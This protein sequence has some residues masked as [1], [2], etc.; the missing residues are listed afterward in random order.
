MFLMQNMIKFM[1]GILFLVLAAISS[2]ASA[3]VTINGYTFSDDST[4]LHMNPYF[5]TYSRR[6]DFQTSLYGY[7][8]FGGYSLSQV[9]H[10]TF[11]IEG[12]ECIVIRE[13]ISIPK[14]GRLSSNVDVHNIYLYYAKD[15]LDNIHVL[16]MAYYG[17]QGTI[18]WDYTDLPE[19]NTTLKYPKSPTSGQEIF[20]G[21]VGFKILPLGKAFFTTLVF[22]SLPYADGS[23]T[24]YLTYGIGIF[25][26][27]HNWNSSINGY[28]KTGFPPELLEDDESSWDEWREDH[29]FISASSP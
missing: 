8:N 11:T 27:G 24:E 1:V 13:D 16:Q 19:G 18:I 23:I 14:S 25:S 5:S 17:D 22:D 10:Q 2:P 4:E 15:T 21:K 6:V 12:I 3:D 7:G 9:F 20:F 29:C 28:S 26:M